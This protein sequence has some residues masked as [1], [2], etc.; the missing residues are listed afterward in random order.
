MLLPQSYLYPNLLEGA[1]SVGAIQMHGDKEC[2]FS[3]ATDYGR[4][5]RKGAENQGMERACGD[6]N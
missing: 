1:D 6:D 2:P 5:W 3:G 4:V